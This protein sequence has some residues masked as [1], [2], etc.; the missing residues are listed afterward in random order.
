MSLGV[1]R[2]WKKNLIN[3]MIPSKNQ[4]FQHQSNSLLDRFQLA[5]ELEHLAQHQLQQQHFKQYKV[6]NQKKPENQKL[7]P[8]VKMMNSY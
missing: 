6:V 1:H 4:K 3:M 8:T 2:I 7:I 5:I